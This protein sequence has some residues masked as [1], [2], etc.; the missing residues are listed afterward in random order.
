MTE[1]VALLN[2]LKGA[3]ARLALSK[4]DWA[5]AA[6]VPA[7]TLSRL[8]HRPNC[9]L[10][11]LTALARAVGM[12]VTLAQQ[13]PPKEM[14]GRWGREEEDAALTLCVKACRYSAG[15]TT[16]G[17]SNVDLAA[18]L[19]AGPRYF[20]AG[21]AVMVANLQCADRPTLMMLAEFLYPGV[22]DPDEFGRWLTQSPA[23]PSRFLA[24]LEAMVH[25]GMTTQP[26]H[27]VGG[28]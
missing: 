24:S 9:E 20:M 11:T 28:H 13:L 8:S 26:P 10:S 15:A 19:G 4:K 27:D 14:P 5:R 7:E 3:S 25:A 17:R 22:T 6:G 1:L 16:V 18:W 12:R 21:L 23:R 2:T